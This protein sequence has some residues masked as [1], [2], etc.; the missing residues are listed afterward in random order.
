MPPYFALCFSFVSQ[1]W[2]ST[3]SLLPALTP[4]ILSPLSRGAVY[5]YWFSATFL[6]NHSVWPQWQDKHCLDHQPQSSQLFS[7][8]SH[9]DIIMCWNI[10]RLLALRAV[11]CIPIT[12]PILHI[13]WWCDLLDVYPGES[14]GWPEVFSH[15]YLGH[16]TGG[17]IQGS[18]GCVHTWFIW[19]CTPGGAGQY[20]LS[21]HVQKHLMA[22]DVINF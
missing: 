15:I 9:H 13:H 11:S 2:A 1:L 12:A 17:W 5:L 18:V 20:L 7:D 22:V 21:I 19:L 16:R 10:S 14:W 6:V 4:L 3:R 8:W